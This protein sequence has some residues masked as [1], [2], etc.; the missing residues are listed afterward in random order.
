LSS[1]I[2]FRVSN[3][4]AYS[5]QP[6]PILSKNCSGVQSKRLS[7][8]T[9]GNTW[10]FEVFSGRRIYGL[11]S[12][13]SQFRLGLMLSSVEVHVTESKSSDFAKDKRSIV[14]QE[15]PQHLGIERN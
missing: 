4:S 1:K 7:K 9:I 2:S 14:L 15:V 13:H 5:E 6:P 11:Y 3:L 8:T 12:S 10:E